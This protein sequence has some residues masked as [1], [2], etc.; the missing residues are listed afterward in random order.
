MRRDDKPTKAKPPATEPPATHP[1]SGLREGSSTPQPSLEE[2]SSSLL[3][4]DPSEE[5]RAPL[6]VEELSGSVLLEDPAAPAPRSHGDGDIDFPTL[7]RPVPAHPVE[8]RETSSPVPVLSEP[9]PPAEAPSAG[10]A[11]K[12]L[13]QGA[14]PVASAWG[15]ALRRVRKTI[16]PARAT[17]APALGRLPTPMPPPKR[18]GE[19]TAPAGPVLSP[20][21]PPAAPSSDVEVT[22]LPHG[23]LE[24]LRSWLRNP[25]WRGRAP[26]RPAW[27][28]GGAGLV[29]GI[30]ISDPGF[31]ELA[32]DER[33]SVGDRHRSGHSRPLR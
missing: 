26:M 19:G 24:A 28:L 11:E 29:L 2:I 10:V 16:A 23:R 33:R 3:L 21:R 14:G 15:D 4:E 8:F 22:R 20:T 31:E 12:P 13:A 32:G 18:Q 17:T 30:G 25:P 6:T 5:A 9:P 1:L 27:W 7:Q